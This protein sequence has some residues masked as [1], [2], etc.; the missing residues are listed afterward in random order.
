[1]FCF[2]PVASM[3]VTTWCGYWAKVV[4]GLPAASADG[5]A[6]QG[7]TVMQDKLVHL[8]A[9]TA[10]SQTPASLRRLM[11]SASS[12]TFVASIKHVVIGK[13]GSREEQ[14]WGCLL[15]AVRY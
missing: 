4:T 2:R 8:L 7:M 11:K 9:A 5:R 14:R 6:A 15:H 12:D 13:G 3:I 1:M 10:G